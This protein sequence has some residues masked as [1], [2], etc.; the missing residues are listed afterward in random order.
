[1]PRNF[2]ISRPLSRGYDDTNDAV[3]GGRLA[4]IGL[5][6]PFE[7]DTIV[8]LLPAVY[9]KPHAR[10]PYAVKKVSHV[11]SPLLMY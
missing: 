8:G 10:I 5:L 7:P 9:V 1:M 6:F 11:H 4:Y 3:I 2:H